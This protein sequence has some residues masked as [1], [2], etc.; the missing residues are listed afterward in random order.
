MQAAAYL[1]V[2]TDE[3]ALEG[4]SLAVQEAECR[5]R[6][7]AEGATEVVVYRD[8]GLSGMSWERPGLQSLLAALPEY[9]L[10]VCW[11]KDRL[12]RDLQH[13]LAIISALAENGVKLAVIREHVETE[14]ADGILSLQVTGAVGE[15]HARR[16]SENVKAALDKLARDGKL[17]CSTV[18]GYERNADGCLVPE[19]EEAALVQAAYSRLLAGESGSE[20]V[21]WLNAQPVHSPKGRRWRLTSLHYILRNPIYCG[22]LRWHDETLPGQHVELVSLA[23][24]Q[25]AQRILDAR[26]QRHGRK[27]NTFAPLF[28]CIHC[29]GPMTSSIR[30]LR[31]GDLR[32]YHCAAQYEQ[33][34]LHPPV[35]LSD[36]A[37]V[38]VIYRHTELLLGERVLE[39]AVVAAKAEVRKGRKLERG[40]QKQLD[41]LARERQ[42]NLKALRDGLVSEVDFAAANA[43]LMAE[44]ARLRAQLPDEG[45]E[46]ELAAIDRLAKLK[47]K[48]LLRRL[49]K[50]S[51]EE[52]VMALRQLYPTI[53]VGKRRLVFHHAGGLLEPVERP[54]PKL[55]SPLRGV[56]DLGF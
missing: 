53:E 40:T 6:A 27:V 42:V 33:A 5:K 41:E 55:Y 31:T 30:K 12:A 49:R 52:Q 1:R 23:D 13:L 32:Y 35:S 10:L 9:E 18:F 24:W 8:E 14:T 20:L 7:L 17:P 25:A 11:T 26:S 21:R 51:V 22:Q 2:S 39:E 45:I 3:Q 48:T 47:P 15:F 34:G 28:R 36:R 19:P 16:T 54:V 37:A 38:A 50:L 44:E 4:L 43:P 56:T 46:E 29:G